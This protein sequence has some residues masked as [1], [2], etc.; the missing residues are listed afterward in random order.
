MAKLF[1]GG[2]G[3]DHSLFRFRRN[4]PEFDKPYIFGKTNT[5]IIGAHAAG[6]WNNGANQNLRVTPGNLGVLAFDGGKGAFAQWEVELQGD[7]KVRIKSNKSGKYLRIMK[8]KVDVEGGQG[9][10]TL[11]KVHKGKLGPVAQHARL[12]SVE[13]GTFL[14]CGPELFTNHYVFGK[15]NTV[16]LK[17]EAGDFL[18]VT[19]GNLN[20]LDGGGKK[21]PFAQWQAEPQANGNE[22]KFKSLKSGKYLRIGPGG[23]LNCGGDGG[24]FTVF[25]VHKQGNGKVKLESKK[26]A[27]Q[28]PA[29]RDNKVQKGNGGKFTV[30]EIFRIN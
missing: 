24:P 12:Q 11:F 1:A 21:G 3:S 28:Y 8:G 17:H 14:N 15:V 2:Q 6:G 26:H 9:K 16:V 25:K 7:N 19:P 22:C 30:F 4:G 18:R 10:F 23:N 5:V 27:G 29:F 13:E 20:A